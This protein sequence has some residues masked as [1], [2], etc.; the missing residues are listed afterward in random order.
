MCRRPARP[1]RRSAR[2]RSQSGT[3]TGLARGPVHADVHELPARDHLGPAGEARGGCGTRSCRSRR[4]SVVR[5]ISSSSMIRPRNEQRLSTIGMPGPLVE[6]PGE[7]PPDLGEPLRQAAVHPPVDGG[8]VDLARVD[9]GHDDAEGLGVDVGRHRRAEPSAPRRFLPQIAD[10]RRGTSGRSRGWNRP[11][12]GPSEGGASPNGQF[13]P[14]ALEPTTVLRWY[15]FATFRHERSAPPPSPTAEQ[16]RA[17]ACLAM[18]KAP[19]LI[20]FAARYT[21]S[22]HD[23]EDAYQRSMEIALTGRA[24]HRAPALH[25][26]APHGAPPRGA[27]GGPG[28]AARGSRR[29]SA[30]VAETCADRLAD[31]RR[32]STP[33]PSGASATASSRTAWPG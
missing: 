3:G 8:E 31:A 13:S 28:P 21:R 33:S 24:G 20:R 26:L 14:A 30:D 32:R 9:L 18:S 19:G 6:D 17:A 16:R 15:V 11:G 7:R 23:A 4:R 29:S 22:L 5:T 25:G 2:S 27:R 1:R 12:H 10:L